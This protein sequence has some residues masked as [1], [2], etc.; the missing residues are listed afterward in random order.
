MKRMYGLTPYPQIQLIGQRKIDL[1]QTY[2][3]VSGYNLPEGCSSY[4]L[5]Q[6]AAL[7]NPTG[8]DFFPACQG[9]LSD[10][11]FASPVVKPSAP[12]P[13]AEV[14]EKKRKEALEREIELVKKEYEE[15]QKRKKEK[16]EEKDSKDDK[17]KSKESSKEG[18]SETTGKTEALPEV[19]KDEAPKLFALH[20]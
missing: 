12:P 16:D 10:K 18:P 2:N 5:R 6:R 17:D 13:S 11:G 15:K 7:A 3:C 20:R 19:K 14:L 1:L 9:H 4:S 8:Q